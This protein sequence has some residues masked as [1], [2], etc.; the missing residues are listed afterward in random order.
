[1]NSWESS[2]WKCCCYCLCYCGCSKILITCLLGQITWILKIEVDFWFIQ[3]TIH[4]AILSSHTGSKWTWKVQCGLERMP[5]RPGSTLPQKNAPLLKPI[6]IIKCLAQIQNLQAKIKWCSGHGIFSRTLR[7]CLWMRTALRHPWVSWFSGLVN[8]SWGTPVL[9]VLLSF[10]FTTVSSIY[11]TINIAVHSLQRGG[12][13]LN[14]RGKQW[15]SWLFAYSVITTDV[16]SW[17]CVPP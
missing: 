10:E 16:V 5:H 6:K 9:A 1:M 12:P 3:P 15:R 8:W 13:T 4:T 7:T 14:Y 17:T 11:F 2:S